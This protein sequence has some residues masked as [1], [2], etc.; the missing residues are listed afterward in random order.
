[1]KEKRLPEA[2]TNE[3][4]RLCIV[5]RP[6]CSLPWRGIVALLAAFAAFSIALAVIF[7]IAGA[8]WVAPF[9]GLELLVIAMA[10]R[11]LYRH[12]GDLELI[13]VTAERLR[14]DRRYG[15]EETRHEFQRYWARVNL[16]RDRD[17][18]YPSRLLIGSHGR[19]VEIGAWLEETGRQHLAQTLTAALHPDR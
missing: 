11:V 7:G 14:I 2:E 18:W 3:I 8:W 10:F 1:M 6:N 17:G 19:F 13:V 9:S 12:R 4:G 15:G 16:E 5:L